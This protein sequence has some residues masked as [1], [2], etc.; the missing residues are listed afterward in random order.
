MANLGPVLHSVT[1]SS[2]LNLVLWVWLCIGATVVVGW[3][4]MAPTAEEAKGRAEAVERL[5]AVFG[6]LILGLVAKSKITGD[7]KR[8]IAN[9]LVAKEPLLKITE[10]PI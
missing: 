6:G 7:Q 2:L 8:E 10:E 4:L 9:A 3:V 5:W 1:R